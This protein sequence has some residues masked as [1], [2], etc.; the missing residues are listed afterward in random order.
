MQSQE[1]KFI[2][3]K[4][5]D[6]RG[7][8][9]LQAGLIGG[10]DVVMVWGSEDVKAFPAGLCVEHSPEISEVIVVSQG[11]KTNLGEV[12]HSFELRFSPSVQRTG[13]PGCCED[14][15]RLHTWRI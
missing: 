2:L 10:P 7:R 14:L 11:Q 9:V 3:H 5:S 13:F 4:N 12:L 1:A 15:V 6:D 8:K